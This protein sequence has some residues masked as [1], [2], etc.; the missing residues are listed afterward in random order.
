MTTPRILIAAALVLSALTALL[1]A[2]SCGI[3]PHPACT[4]LRVQP[5]YTYETNNGSRIKVPD[6]GDLFE[7]LSWTDITEETRNDECRRLVTEYEE[8]T[9]ETA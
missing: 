9:G 3:D 1:A 5:A 4:K 7:E 6:G 8:R 2:G